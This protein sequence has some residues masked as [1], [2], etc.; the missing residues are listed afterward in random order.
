MGSQ[1][2]KAIAG[3]FLEEVI[4]RGNSGWLPGSLCE[5]ELVAIT[6]TRCGTAA[7]PHLLGLVMG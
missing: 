1:E 7:P 4:N 3:R 5:A 6:E 2:N